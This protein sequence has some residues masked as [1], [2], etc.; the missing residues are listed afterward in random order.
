MPL[1][2][3][4][5]I[6]ALGAALAAAAALREASTGGASAPEPP[7]AAQQA[8]PGTLAAVVRA[9]D[10][11]VMGTVAWTR[12]FEIDPGDGAPMVFT[13]VVVRGRTLVGTPV[14]PLETMR[15]PGSTDGAE[16][17]G[18]LTS[19]LV[20]GGLLDGGLR[21]SFTAEAPH[22]HELRTGRGIVAFCAEAHFVRAEGGEL[23]RPMPIGGRAGVFNT[24]VARD[25]R[26]I[27]QGRSELGPLRTNVT[28][29]ALEADV[30]RM[31]AGDAQEQR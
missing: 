21:G 11:V 2:T 22:R 27:V 14:A 26:T 10:T 25:G 12:A 24:F 16:E 15:S 20:P 30:A 28:L 4:T 5:T 18:A 9:A 19:F 17:P 3:P 31:R 13:E 29:D 1:T 7:A 23:R 6:L 8:V